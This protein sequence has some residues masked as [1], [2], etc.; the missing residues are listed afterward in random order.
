VRRSIL[1]D[2][3]RICSS[4]A[5]ASAVVEIA[6]RLAAGES[7]DAITDLRGTAFSR[8]AGTPR[9]DGWTE[10]DSTTIDTGR[11]RRPSIPYA[12]AA[13]EGTRRTPAR[14]RH[15]LELLPRAS[16]AAARRPRA[17]GGAHARL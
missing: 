17:L 12:M 9:G 14:P 11:P 3:R 13:S 2:S 6:H 4:T 8:P 5:T 7:A 16:S 10:I 1:I 15:R